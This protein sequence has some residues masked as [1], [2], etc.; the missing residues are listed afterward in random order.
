MRPGL[1][2][3]FS[4]THAG[5][6]M[7]LYVGYIEYEIVFLPIWLKRNHPKGNTHRGAAGAKQRPQKHRENISAPPGFGRVSPDPVSWVSELGF[8]PALFIKEEDAF[9]SPGALGGLYGSQMVNDFRP[10]S[11]TCGWKATCSS[12]QLTSSVCW[13]Q[14]VIFNG[15]RVQRSFIGKKALWWLCN[16]LSFNR[17]SCTDWK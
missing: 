16:Q 2:A 10:G 6:L 7:V 12:P 8:H 17:A 11:R 5:F 4:R 3:T 13:H 1:R 9:A 15:T 14:T